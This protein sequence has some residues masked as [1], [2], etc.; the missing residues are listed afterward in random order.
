MDFNVAILW[1]K[2]SWIILAALIGGITLVWNFFNKTFRE[3]K[4][5]ISRPLD[6][7]K[8]DLK[9]VK[10]SNKLLKGGVLSMQRQ[11]L[12]KSCEDYL[13]RGEITLE[14]RE[15]VTK[16][17]ESYHALGGDSFITQLVDEVNNLPLKK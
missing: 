12:L 4:N 10:D 8:E 14:Q 1:L 17:Y 7:I 9:D 13:T 3:I 5:S 6:D 2:D 15:T 16:Q 11:S